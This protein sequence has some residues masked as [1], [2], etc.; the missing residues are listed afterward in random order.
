M[1][2]K[3]ELDKL[4]EKYETD[5]VV[6]DDETE[7]DA[8]ERAFDTAKTLFCLLPLQEKTCYMHEKIKS[9]TQKCRQLKK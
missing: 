5:K 8:Y 4:V 6:K 7:F 3:T 1:I 2:T 9:I